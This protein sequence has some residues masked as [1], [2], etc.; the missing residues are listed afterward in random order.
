MAKIDKIPLGCMGNKTRELKLLL[1]IIEPHITKDTIFI[2]PF[3]GSC[4]VSFNVFKKHN[5]IKFHINDIDTLRIKFYNN[6]KTEEGRNEFYELQ[7]QVLDTNGGD[8]IY[9][10]IIGKNKCKMT[11]DYNAYIISKTIYSF[12]MGL[13]PTTKKVNKKII[14]ENWINFFNEATI[15]NKDFKIILD[16]Y[17]DNENAFIYLDPPYMDSYNAG[18]SG[19]YTGKSHDE[20]MKI[21]DNTQIYIDLLDFLKCKCKILFSINSNALTRYV[22]KDYIKNDYTHIYQASHINIDNVTQKKKHTNVLIISN[23]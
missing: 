4:I 13:Y 3:S 20:D 21:I 14:S 1:P 6:M 17:K 11:T 2:E 7:D 23:L 10:E 15:T 5:N 9:Y 8:S 16:Q 19:A 18:Y 12:R 22:Y